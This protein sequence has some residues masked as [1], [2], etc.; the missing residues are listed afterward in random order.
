MSCCGKQRMQT[1]AVK[2]AAPEESAP[3]MSPDSVW[4]QYVGTTGL[5]ALGAITGAR[6]RFNSP[7]A[8]VAVDPRDQ[9]S[10]RAIP[11]LRPVYR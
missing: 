6:Y 10:L 8:I 2:R 1:P 11:Y 5:T 4:L 7:G 9:A 3:P